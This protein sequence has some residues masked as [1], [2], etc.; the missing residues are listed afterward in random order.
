MR[1]IMVLVITVLTTIVIFTALI[2][3]SVQNIEPKV[4]SWEAA[5]GK[6][7]W[8]DFGCIQCHALVGNG[9]Y[10]APDLTNVVA[11][12]GDQWLKNFFTN[13]PLMPS[14]K[15]RHHK[16]LNQEQIS[17]LL[18]YLRLVGELNTL[19]WP[20]SPRKNNLELKRIN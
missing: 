3:Y 4:I 2:Y 8:E 10:A 17:F 20:P 12:R 14:S 6:K 5:Q 1:N 11:T 15:F 16:K 18:E 13:P 9:G 19:N 7:V